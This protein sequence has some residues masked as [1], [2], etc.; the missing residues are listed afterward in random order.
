[1][2][3]IF[4]ERSLSADPQPQSSASRAKPAAVRSVQVNLAES[5]L[6]WLHARGYVSQ[7]LFAAGDQLRADY[8]RAGLAS[9]TTMDWDASPLVKQGRGANRQEEETVAMVE[10]KLRF[11]GAI[12]HA[13]P[14]FTDILW[15]V[16]CACESLPEIEEK[17]GWPRRSARV[18]L[19]LALD[20][21]ADYYRIN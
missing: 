8:D 3:P 16:V 12:A 10:A 13:G 4:V 6:G 5:P 21:V 20:R 9:R 14:V 11:D 1:M 7:R 2:Q 17:F 18:V 19:S 15:R